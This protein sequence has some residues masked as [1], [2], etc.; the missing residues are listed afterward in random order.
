MLYV[1]DQSRTLHL[2]ATMRDIFG[3]DRFVVFNGTQ[4][5][6]FGDLTVVLQSIHLFRDVIL[7]R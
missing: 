5:V 4:P 7:C 6:R 2:R 1:H 3:D